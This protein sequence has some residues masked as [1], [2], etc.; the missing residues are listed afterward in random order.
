[1]MKGRNT[2][3]LLIFLLVMSMLLACGCSAYDSSRTNNSGSEDIGNRTTLEKDSNDYGTASTT[4]PEEKRDDGDTTDATAPEE[5]NSGNGT[6]SVTKQEED[7]SG[8]DTTSA[9]QPEDDNGGNSTTST[10]KPE[11]DNSG[12]DRTDATVPEEDNSG[13]GTASPTK[14]EDSSSNNNTTSTTTPKEDNGDNGTT[15]TTIN[16]TVKTVLNGFGAASL[17]HYISAEITK[18]CYVA[19]GSV[20]A[21][22]FIGH[23]TFRDTVA[24][25]DFLLSKEELQ[26]CSFSIV[27]NYN[28]KKSA[29][30]V[31]NIDYIDAAY[32]VSIRDI[33]DGEVYKGSNVNYSKYHSIS[34]D[35]NKMTS[36]SYGFVNIELYITLSDGTQSV[37]TDT[38]LYYSV[39]D[40]EI[41]FGLR[42]NPAAHEGD[43]GVIT[44]GW[45][46]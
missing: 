9:T 36:V 10:T 32:K 7:N 28:G 12:H 31:N 13:N 20:A 5:G 30:V 24:F 29:T 26:N 18:R 43:E 8:N 6:T 39:V 35:L 27:V 38:T 16:G 45:T 4:V 17:P 1:M 21:K 33:Y 15:S 46:Y 11:E 25:S 42:S 14:P 22:V 19:E 40:G 44:H 3:R 37:V 41:V 2:K 34:L 23:P